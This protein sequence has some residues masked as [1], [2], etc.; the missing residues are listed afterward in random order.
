M[1]KY[2]YFQIIPVKVRHTQY[3]AT[4]EGCTELSTTPIK[5]SHVV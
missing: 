4:P 5:V 1:R 3:Q 2:A